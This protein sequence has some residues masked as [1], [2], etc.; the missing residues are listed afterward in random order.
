MKVPDVVTST[1]NPSAVEE[2]G[3]GGDPCNLPARQ[4]HLLSEFQASPD[5]KADDILRHDT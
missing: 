3:G 2:T 5:N 4:L 1:P